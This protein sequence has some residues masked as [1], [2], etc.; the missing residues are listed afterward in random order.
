VGNESELARL[1]AINS[2]QFQEL[3]ADNSLRVKG[4]GDAEPQIDPAAKMGRKEIIS[5]LIKRG[6]PRDRATQ[7]ADVFLEYR[8]ASENIEKNGT[9][10]SH[11]RTGVPMANPY[12][13]IRDNAL[14]KFQSFQYIEAAF[15]WE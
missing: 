9:L 14:K 8:E 12:L 15:L 1:S 3:L 7:Y 4:Q 11:P 10:V 2:E 5:G 13:A 6:A